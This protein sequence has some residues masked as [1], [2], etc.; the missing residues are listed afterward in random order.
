MKIHVRA[1]VVT[2]ALVAALAAIGYGVT[3]AQRKAIDDRVDAHT[4]EATQA[5]QVHAERARTRELELTSRMLAADPGFVGYVAQA[6]AAATETRGTV[7]AA[8]I[9]DLLEERRKDLRLDIAAVLDPTTRHVVVTGDASGGAA[10]MAALP[11]VR[12]VIDGGRAGT[13]TWSEGGRLWLVS[14]TPLLRGST[15]EGVLVAGVAL[16]LAFAQSIARDGHAETALIEIANATPRLVAST[17]TGADAARLL[18]AVEAQAA[19][20]P[21]EAGQAMPVR[22]FD[23]EFEGGQT[24][25]ALT[26]LFASSD[27]GLFASI[28]PLDRKVVAGG[29]V[30]GPMLIGGAIVLVL[31]LVCAW[32]LQRRV[33]KPI[34]DLADLSL[35]MLRGD[36]QLAARTTGTPDV[37]RIGEAFNQVLADLRGYKEAIE[38]RQKRP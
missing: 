5:L 15:L 13:A 21:V 36:H 18:A 28:V 14:A 31:V 35:R 1:A 27:T 34:A 3:L 4:L 2:L 12:S 9:R 11:L 8:S 30:R 38:Q 16:D 24:R 32:V 33:F 25:A 26:P 23:V 29:A 6:L 20:P 22:V 17:V 19:L 7:D 37:A 10:A